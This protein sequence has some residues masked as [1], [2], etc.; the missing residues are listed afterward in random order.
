LKHTVSVSRKVYVGDRL[1]GEVFYSR[2]F[3]D[4]VTPPEASFQA[5]SEQV[6]RWA[7]ELAKR[8]TEK[9]TAEEKLPS[10]P[11]A[12][13][14]VEDAE[15]LFPEELASLLSFEDAGDII[16]ARPKRYLGSDTFRKIAVFVQDHLGGEYVSA[17][18]DSH[19][20]IPKTGGP[21][22]TIG[23][24]DEEKPEIPDFDPMDLLEHEGWKAKR[25]SDG[26][27][28]KGSLNWG[29]DFADNFPRS[30][31]RVLEKGPFEIDRYVFTLNQSGNL[32]QARRK[33]KEE[34]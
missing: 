8:W 32:V 2:E 26:T 10:K 22:R 21:V 6:D 28:A 19:W 27:Y 14:T 15:K 5:V 13:R 18:R 9:P 29:W 34:D 16:V 24:I 17:G 12:I 25:L 23:F 11:A 30:V 3:D 7:E 1:L 4:A 33:R 31:I 20:R